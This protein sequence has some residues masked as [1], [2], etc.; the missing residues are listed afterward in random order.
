MFDI[1]VKNIIYNSNMRKLFFILLIIFLAVGA[2]SA[3]SYLS[4]DYDGI[5]VPA[6]SF[7]QVISLQDFSTAYSDSTNQ[8]KFVCT[9][10][11]FE[12]E[13]KI[14][15]KG[16]VFY[17]FIEKKNEPVIGTHASMVVRITKMVYQDGFTIPIR[18]YIHTTN[19]N[20]IGGQMT[21]PEI[22]DKMPHYQEKIARHFVG[23]LQYVPGPTR[24]MGE[25]VTVAAGANLL[26][27]LSEPA[28]I[29]HTLSD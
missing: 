22:Y 6:G 15:P 27:V 18:G 21:E 9:N 12:F 10:D 14:I 17:G 16:T 19:G 13:T 2:V 5:E 4:R 26:I 23:V 3:E 8:L 29:T 7:I 1:N 11:I 25:H 28:Y 24:K 20:K